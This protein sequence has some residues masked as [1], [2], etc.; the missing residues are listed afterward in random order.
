MLLTDSPSGRHQEL[1]CVTILDSLLETLIAMVDIENGRIYEVLNPRDPPSWTASNGSK[2]IQ[3][4]KTVGVVSS[5]HRVQNGFA[6][7]A[8]PRY[9]RFYVVYLHVCPCYFA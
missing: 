2:V 5:G 3:R 9:S 1:P 6:N 4:S 7:Y 8:V